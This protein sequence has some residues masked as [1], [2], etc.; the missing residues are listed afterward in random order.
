[1]FYGKQREEGS[2]LPEFTVDDLG[3][4]FK[5]VLVNSVKVRRSNDGPEAYIPDHQGLIKRIAIT[6]SAHP[7]KLQGGDIRFLRK[8]LGLRAKDLAAKLDISPEHLSR[9][10][11]CDKTLSPNSEK[12][13]RSLVIFEAVYVLRKA[14]EDS[15]CA[16]DGLMEKMSKLL[17]DLEQIISGMKISSLHPADEELVLYFSRV[18][19]LTKPSANDSDD[20]KLEWLD[21]AA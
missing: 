4:A 17:D 5:I 15:D 14:I 19:P 3:T 7:R 6:R 20:K 21:K 11:A 13:L 2:I 12:V 16:K 8:S 9:C 1:M 10:E 18:S